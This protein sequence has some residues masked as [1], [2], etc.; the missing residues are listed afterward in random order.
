[1]AGLT[2]VFHGLA[3]TGF[4]VDL[5]SSWVSTNEHTR[6]TMGVDDRNFGLRTYLAPGGAVVDGDGPSC[7]ARRFHDSPP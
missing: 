4:W 1:M 5:C 6:E 2:C 3:K 7:T